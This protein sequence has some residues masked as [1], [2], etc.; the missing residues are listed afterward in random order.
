MLVASDTSPISNLAIIGRLSLLR[1]QFREIWIPGAVQTELD[2][3]SNPAA[4]KEI[5]QALQ[6]GWIKRQALRGDKV[7]RLLA[8]DIDPGEAE[9]IALALELSADLILLDE[10]DGRSAAE[11][12]GL[13]VTGIL[14]VLLRAKN[15]GQI[16]LIKPEIEALRTQA[17]FFLSARLQEKVLVIAGE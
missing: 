6:D 13:R 11:R 15:D 7:A 17:R 10:R 8:A 12:A 9:A 2:Q 14:G 16:P 3:L 4:L 1:S 5:Q